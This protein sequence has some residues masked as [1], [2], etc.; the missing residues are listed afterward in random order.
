MTRYVELLAVGLKSFYAFKGT[1]SAFS[2]SIESIFGHQTL[3]GARISISMPFFL[4]SPTN[5]ILTVNTSL[6]REAVV[7]GYHY[8]EIIVRVDVKV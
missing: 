5:G 7:N 6:Q 3:D 8:F 2:Y 1:N 4:I